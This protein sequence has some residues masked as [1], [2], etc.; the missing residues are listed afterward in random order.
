LSSITFVSPGPISTY[1]TSQRAFYFA[2]YLAEREFEVNFI[3]RYSKLDQ[4]KFGSE[5]NGVKIYSEPFPFRLWRMKQV[6]GIIHCIKPQILSATP[7]LFSSFVFKRR[8][9]LEMDEWDE[10]L[11][12]NIR[13]PLIKLLQDQSARHAEAILVGS[14][15]LKEI[16]SKW[17]KK[18]FL[19]PYAVDLNYY[20][21]TKVGWEK[22]REKISAD[23]VVLYSG[24]LIPRYDVDLII[25]AADFLTKEFTNI[26][27][28]I[29]GK[30]PMKPILEKQ[31]RNRDLE[32]FFLFT[33]YVKRE[34]LAKFQTAADVL[35]FPIR[36]NFYNLAR[37]PQ[38]LYEYMASG[39][40]IVTNP[41]RE[42]RHS[43]G[44]NTFYFKF[45]DP[46]DF[47]KKIRYA[48]L[49]PTISSKKAKNARIE[50]ESRFNLVSYARKL[51]KIYAHL[52]NK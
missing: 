12:E 15:F 16:F 13:R 48:L 36:L 26:K 42:I 11:A 20:D 51:L 8:F 23:F 44:T 46:K 10:L 17:R 37:N 40:V 28:V 34:L 50:V 47:A 5:Y 33:G 14:S 32:R 43:L 35:V 6:D 39:R 21:K 30:G 19:F 38:K 7:T 2:Q 52:S 25:K 49:N 41:I 22:I 3:S 18:L 27:F 4:T 29:V 9:V 24:W 45:N 1:A 31:V